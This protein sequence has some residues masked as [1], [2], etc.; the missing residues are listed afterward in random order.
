MKKY[1]LF[2]VH[3][4]KTAALRRLGEVFDS[5][6]INEG[7]QVTQLT[8]AM[9][10]RFQTE[11][12][13]LA[14]SCTSTISMALHLAG[15]RRF[16]EVVSTPMTCVAT[17]C[18]IVTAQADIAWAD[19]DPETGCIEPASVELALRLNPQVWNNQ[20]MPDR[21]GVKAVIAV[22]WAGNPPPLREL[23][24]LCDRY[25]TRLI[26]DA[27]HAFGSTYEGAQLAALPDYT[28]YS[29]QAI[30]HFTT[31]DGGML[32]CRDFADWQ[33]SKQLKWF[34]IDRDAAKDANGDWKG[35]HWD[36]DIRN[37]GYKFNMNNVAA[38]IGLS[39]LPHID[40]LLKKHQDNADLYQELLANSPFVTPLRVPSG[41]RS[42]SW[43]YTVL[44]KDELKAIRDPLLAKLNSCGIMAGL[45]HVPN[46]AYTC[47]TKY[48]KV[49]PGVQSFFDR[50][51]SL[52][53]GWWLTQADI[54]KIVKQLNSACKELTK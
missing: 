19:I 53:V 47:F 54:K 6:F 7:V 14:N 11:Q 43:V 22:A 50:Q 49:L 26:L 24:E 36:F 34:G 42:A 27:A 13:V 1:P 18:P 5:G 4:D 38:A 29:F 20:V 51:L 45:V 37:A 40:G 32:I 46:D 28:C 15:V 48:R 44:L 35:Q 39:Q 30:K 52:P 23:R 21:T 33:R 41:S 25:S 9:E 8:Q 17:N 2:K 10:Q 16:D 3:V 31:G 12:L